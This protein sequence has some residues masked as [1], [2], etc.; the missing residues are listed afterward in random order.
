MVVQPVRRATAR[1]ALDADP[2]PRLARRIGQRV[3]AAGRRPIDGQQQRQVL[4]GPE[5]GQHAAVGRLQIERG[6]DFALLHLAR[7]AQAARATPAPRLGRVVAVDRLLGIDQDLRQHAIGLAPGADDLVGRRFA[8]HVADRLQQAA[9]D[10]RIVLGL[11]AQRG[12]LLHDARQRA[13]QRLE[14]IDMAGEGEHRAGQ[15][16]GLRAVDLVGLVEEGLQ[17]RMLGQQQP[18][19]M[20]GDRFAV[21]LQHGHR[22]LDQ[23]DGIRGQHENAPVVGRRWV[24]YPYQ[25]ACQRRWPAQALDFYGTMAGGCPNDHTNREVTKTTTLST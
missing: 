16:P 11:D 5:G 20:L 12:V 10:D 18:I 22:G 9:A 17:L 8:Q 7:N 1:L 21:L 3:V 15:R 4:S 24:P 6:N 25:A 14:L 2:V 13:G 23:R 19:E